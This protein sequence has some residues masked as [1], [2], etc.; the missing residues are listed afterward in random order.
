MLQVNTKSCIENPAETFNPLLSTI[1]LRLLA[2]KPDD[3]EYSRLQAIITSL[4]EE[5]NNKEKLLVKFE[6][7]FAAMRDRSTFDVSGNEE[8]SR[9]R[10]ANGISENCWLMIAYRAR[11]DIYRLDLEDERKRIAAVVID[12]EDQRAALEVRNTKIISVDI[13]KPVVGRPFSYSRRAA[14]F[15]GRAPKGQGQECKAV[16]HFCSATTSATF[17]ESSK[18][19]RCT[20]NHVVGYYLDFIATSEEKTTRVSGGFFGA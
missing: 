8:L 16:E 2:K 12:L 1:R 13:L 4:R 18:N 14:R 3:A 15:G 6:D 7:H 17:I 10:L 9:E 19:H 11:L 20:R 5:V